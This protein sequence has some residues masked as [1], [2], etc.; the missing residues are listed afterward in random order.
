MVWL[1]PGWNS[2]PA[3]CTC[4]LPW[5]SFNTTTSSL[6]VVSFFW[7]ALNGLFQR[8]EQIGSITGRIPN[9]GRDRDQTKFLQ[10]TEIPL[11]KNSRTEIED[12]CTSLMYVA[13]PGINP[14][15]PAE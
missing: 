6:C 4:H 12:Y 7:K 9:A 13:F 14:T 5:K 1:D 2:W 10:K 8:E 3:H 11:S 15:P